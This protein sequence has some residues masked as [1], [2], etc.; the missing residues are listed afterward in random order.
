MS[1]G[2]N[3]WYLIPDNRASYN[4]VQTCVIENFKS[5]LGQKFE[6]RVAE[7]VVIITVV[8]N[9]FDGL[10]TTAN[11]TKAYLNACDV[12]LFKKKK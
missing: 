8:I 12:Y 1:F 7:N 6:S 3:V 11:I 5:H 10:V 4:N 2:I 9:E